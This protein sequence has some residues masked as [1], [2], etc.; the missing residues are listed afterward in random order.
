[1]TRG[2][3]F[4]RR[5]HAGLVTSVLALVAS[6]GAAVGSAGVANSAGAA[7]PVAHSAP[8][9]KSRSGLLVLPLRGAPP[10]PGTRRVFS[11]N[12]SPVAS[13]ATLRGPRLRFGCGD[14]PERLNRMNLSAGTVVEFRR[15]CSWRDVRVILRGTG[16]VGQPVLIQSWGPGA[17]PAPTFSARKAGRFKDDAVISIEGSNIHVRDLAVRNSASVGFGANGTRTVLH[18][19]EGAG[20]VIGA[21]VRGRYAKV[22]NSYFHDLRM[23]P[24]TPGP[25]DDYGASGVVIEAHDVSVEGLTCRNCIGRSPDYDQWGGDGSFAEVWMK[26]DR[27]RL[28]YGYADRTPRVLEAGGLG[29]QSARNMLVTNI[30]AR[31]ISDAPFYFNPSGEYSGIATDGF[32]QRD[33][34]IV[35]TN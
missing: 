20:V 5:I 31:S 8:A 22:W 33:N 13:A 19:V 25:N 12:R 14:N 30:Y 16:T 9:P 3:G 2:S 1:M 35:R 29:R 11:P 7:S 23:M 24:D 21:W 15:G 18:H 34:V 32:L 27:L 17:L 28:R 6:G 26:G 4:R 10:N